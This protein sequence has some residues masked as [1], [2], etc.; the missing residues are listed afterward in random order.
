MKRTQKTKPGRPSLATKDPE[1]EKAF[2][3]CISSGMS[4]IKTAKFFR[5]SESTVK[6]YRKRLG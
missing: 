4:I 2:R 6:R 1:F 3:E 5:I